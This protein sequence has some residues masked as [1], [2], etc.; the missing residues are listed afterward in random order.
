MLDCVEGR[1]KSRLALFS[2]HFHCQLLINYRR[3][4]KIGGVNGQGINEAITRNQLHYVC[5]DV[6]SLEND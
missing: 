4:L 6:L 2:N 3:H 1:E 5:F